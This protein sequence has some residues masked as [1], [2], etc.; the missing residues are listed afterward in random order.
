MPC[1]KY[2][3]YGILLPV[4]T[5]EQ[6]YDEAIGNNGIITARHARKL[7][8]P[9][10]ALVKLCKRGRLTHVGHGVYRIDKY[11]P[12]E[13]DLYATAVARVGEGAYIIGESVIGYYKLCPTH[14][15][16][17]HVGTTRRVR[18]HLPDAIRI[19]KRPHGER[20]HL[21]DGIPAQAIG[22]AIRTARA[23]VEPSRLR[24]AIDAAFERQLIL[25][26]EAE[27]LKRELGNEQ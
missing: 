21:M 19:E 5:Y 10:I 24:E 8:I 1:Q 12:Q 22:L 16:I 15:A 27:E 26:S 2:A 25:R 18:R 4:T 20:L 6:I 9:A 11:F 7:G 14:E 13:T 3:I 17:V 23:T